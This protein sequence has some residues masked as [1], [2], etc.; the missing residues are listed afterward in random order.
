MTGP[1]RRTLLRGGCLTAV[2]L[3]MPRGAAAGLLDDLDPRW[4]P[5]HGVAPRV[6]CPHDGCRHHRAVDG[7]FCGLSLGGEV[8]PEG[9]S[10]AGGL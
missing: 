8:V 3:S 1:T 7:G 6:G 2:L 5:T 4:M 10:E 9:G